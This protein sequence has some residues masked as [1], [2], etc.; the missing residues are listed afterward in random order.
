MLKEGDRI[1]VRCIY[2]TPVPW[3]PKPKPKGGTDEEW[4]EWWEK[5]RAMGFTGQDVLEGDNILITHV[6]GIRGNEILIETSTGV[7]WVP[8][9]WVKPITVLPSG[10]LRPITDPERSE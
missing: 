2:D 7:M 1:I 8:Q 9:H 5:I 6:K 3:P 4:S 10:A